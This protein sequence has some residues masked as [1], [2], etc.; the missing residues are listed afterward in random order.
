MTDTRFSTDIRY[1]QMS[2][3]SADIDRIFVT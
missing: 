3:L 1:R 2:I